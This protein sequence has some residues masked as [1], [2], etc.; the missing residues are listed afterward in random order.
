[1]GTETVSPILCSPEGQGQKWPQSLANRQ[2][3]V[4][5]NH[6]EWTWSSVLKPFPTL[7]LWDSAF[8]DLLF[9]ANP[10]DTPG[11]TE[12]DETAFWRIERGRS[13]SLTLGSNLPVP[14]W[15]TP[16]I[17]DQTNVFSKKDHSAHWWP[18]ILRWEKSHST[19]TVVL[20]THLIDGYTAELRSTFSPHWSPPYP[21]RRGSS[22]LQ[23]N[24]HSSFHS[25]LF[26]LMK[27]LSLVGLS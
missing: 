23:A 1:M 13:K 15:G 25:L 10:S 26:L 3:G 12:K 16:W 9:Q 22:W 18:Q 20:M 8:Q 7:T 5:K 2:T 21:K 17:A 14:A 19:E 27:E 24:S 4:P 11:K 6:V